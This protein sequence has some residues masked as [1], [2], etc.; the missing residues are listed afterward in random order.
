[1]AT[2]QTTTPSQ[3]LLAMLEDKAAQLRIDS[4]RSTT[5]AGSGHPTTC[6]SAAE[7]MSALFFSVMK[8]DPKNPRNRHNDA[9]V[10][11]K[12][13]AAPILYAAW[14]EAGLFPRED[15]MQL[16]KFDSDLEG[17]PT[18]RLPFVDV[19]TGSLGQGACAAVGIALNAKYLDKS[20]Q[21]VY[22][23]LGDGE[24]A[25]GSVWEA[26]HAA[27]F[28]KLDNLCATVDVNRLGQ[29]QPTMDQHKREAHR[30]RW[31][32]FGWNAIV[33]DG[34]D[35]SALLDAYAQAEQTKDR[36]TAVLAHTLKGKGIPGI[37]DKVGYHGKALEPKQA[38]EAIAS[39]QKSMHGGQAQWTPSLPSDGA[40]AVPLSPDAGAQFPPAPYTP[41]K[42]EIPTRKAFG[43]ALAALGK[44]DPRVVA[45][46]GDV[47]NS[48]YTEDF[49]KACP[50]R[51]FEMYI[52]EQNMVGA[53]MGL[54]A[55]GRI[56]FASTFACFISRAYDF[57]RMAA[58]GDNNIKLVGTHAG[59][60]IGEDG[61]SQMGLEDLAMMVAQP[62]ITVLYP[63]DGVSTWQSIKM[64]ADIQ[65]P[66]YVRTGRPKNPVIY[67]ADEHFEAGKSKVV[68][69]SDNDKLTIVAAGVTLFESLKAYEQLK[70]EG[71]NVRVVDLFSVQPIDREGLIAAARATGGRV[72]TVEDHY[73][74]G[75][76]GDAVLSALHDQRVIVEKLAVRKI[77]HSGTPDELL[78]K[79][80][81]SAGHIVE[82]ARKLAAA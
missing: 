62:N 7:I 63:S 6:A 28:H 1:M 72:L 31:A 34:H 64:A 74:S 2:I 68:R 51:F 52:A 78:E 71:I 36:P 66:V 60:S 24:S 65:G 37:A 53:A 54:S 57:V 80:G 55:H 42:D 82:A 69:Q 12:G 67:K 25:E 61:P 15:L 77:P 22:V 79:Y 27:S 8:Y 75:G 47:E 19:A 44:V 43:L 30:A 56:P 76:I 10:L 39:I 20:D 46:D 11:S 81:I 73:A 29:S 23:V 5:A 70:G 50:E 3:E 21:R 14:A 4:I 26:A 48:T 9:F 16:R 45:L 33:V 40:P 38:E 13:H 58:I 41:G 35:V 17:H 18:P 49:Q 59:V 32:A